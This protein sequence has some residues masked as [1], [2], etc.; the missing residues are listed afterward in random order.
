MAEQKAKV[1]KLKEQYDEIAM[2]KRE[3]ENAQRAYDVAMQR[4]GQTRMESEMNQTNIS[5][6]NSA[7]PPSKHTK[8][9]LLLNMI[10][11]IFLG[12]MLVWTLHY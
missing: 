8:P 5:V 12:T 1:L 11:S 2:Y 4:A 3:V 6:L 7:L 10:S 9:R